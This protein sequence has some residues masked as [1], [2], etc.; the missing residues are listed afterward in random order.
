MEAERERRAE[1]I[2]ASAEKESQILVSEGF[3]QESI[4][5]SEG[6]KQKRINEAIGRGR[7]I[8]IM[9][10][11]TSEGVRKVATAI[12]KPGGKMAVKMRLAEQFVKQLQKVIVQSKVSAFPVELATLKGAL[13]AFQSKASDASG[14]QTK[15]QQPGGMP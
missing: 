15:P 1:V 14:S 2:L 5:I 3:R 10:D 11:A 8:A 12:Q 13:D 4:N 6:E 7:E 9:A